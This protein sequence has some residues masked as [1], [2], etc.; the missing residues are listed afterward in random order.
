MFPG[1]QAQRV[2]FQFET[3]RGGNRLLGPAARAAPAE[4]FLDRHRLG[5]FFE[6]RAFHR[7]QLVDARL[8]EDFTQGLD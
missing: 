5:V 6:R 8:V 2:H 7:D 1:I 4:F 3:G